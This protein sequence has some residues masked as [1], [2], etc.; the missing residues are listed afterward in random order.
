MKIKMLA[1]LLLMQ[2]TNVLSQGLIIG[3][4]AAM[5]STSRLKLPKTQVLDK[6]VLFQTINKYDL[7]NKVVNYKF[8]DLRDSLSLKKLNCSDIE[9]KNDYKFNASLGAS[10]VETYLDS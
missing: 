9:L 5:S 1:F 2:I 10:V 4:V 8:L 3:A 6:Y 7:K